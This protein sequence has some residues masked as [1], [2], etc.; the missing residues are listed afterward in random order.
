MSDTVVDKYK[1]ILTDSVV[2]LANNFKEAGF[3]PP[4]KIEVDSLTF[5]KILAEAAELY[6]LD[7]KH[8]IANR[9]FSLSGITIIVERRES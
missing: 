9:E 4:A 2:R 1:T 6:T 5:D 3:N 8:A 7:S